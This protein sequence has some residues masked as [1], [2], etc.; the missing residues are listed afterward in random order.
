MT[1]ELLTEAFG[2]LKSSWTA[3]VR[4]LL[5]VEDDEA[6]RQAIVELIGDDDVQTTAVGTGR[7]RPGRRRRAA[8]FD[9]MVLDLG[10][11]DM[12]GL[13]LL[14]EIEEAVGARSRP[15]LPVIVYTGKDLTRKEETQLKQLAETII[16]KDVRSPERLLDETAL[17]LHRPTARLPEAKR[18]IAGEAA[19]DRPACW[20][21]A[22]C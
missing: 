2:A 9:C 3:S 7:G 11:P 22:R 18:D 16:V 12:T 10:L 14:A 4:T 15:R 1:K 17:F 20:P 13:D 8:H 19:P 6:Q 5:V 21:A